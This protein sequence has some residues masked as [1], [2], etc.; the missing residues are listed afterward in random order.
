MMIRCWFR[1]AGVLGDLM[2]A[3]SNTG[4]QGKHLGVYLTDERRHWRERLRKAK[5]MWE[6]VR[7]LTRLILPPSAKKSIVCGQ[8]YPVLY[9]GCEAFPEPNEE[10]LGRDGWWG[11]GQA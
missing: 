9:Y 11:H 5:G 2:G 7:R 10:M 4:K 8:L 1:L 3:P 6:Q